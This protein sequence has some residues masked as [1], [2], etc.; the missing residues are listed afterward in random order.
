MKYAFRLL[1]FCWLI[2]LFAGQIAAQTPLHFLI[3]EEALSGLE[4]Y[5]IQ[6]DSNRKI[7]I[8][9]NDGLLQYDG[10]RFNRV[11][12]PESALSNDVLGMQ[13]DR[14]GRLFY[15]NLSGQIFTIVNDRPE[16]FLDS[17]FPGNNNLEK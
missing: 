1:L 11:P 6:Q 15:Y 17:I 16:V 3:G 14:T 2:G 4:V 13:K 12:L 10:Y 8:G 7:W 5:T 9:T